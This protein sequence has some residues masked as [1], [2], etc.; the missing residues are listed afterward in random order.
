MK[1]STRTL[2]CGECVVVQVNIMSVISQGF[3]YRPEEGLCSQ[4]VRKAAPAPAQAPRLLSELTATPVSTGTDN[5]AGAGGDLCTSKGLEVLNAHIGPQ[6]QD[7][8][9]LTD[10]RSPH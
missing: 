2:T 10:N 6:E 5:S 3:D 7:A 4:A 9:L 1:A 8:L